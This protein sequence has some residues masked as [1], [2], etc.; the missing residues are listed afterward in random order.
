MKKLFL[1][2]MLFVS[3]GSYADG[4]VFWHCTA[5][6]A[7]G[8]VWN[9]YGESHQHTRAI[10]QKACEAFNDRKSCEMVCF[11]PRV[12]WRCMSHDL[13]SA[14]QTK[15]DAAPIKPGTWYWTSF[16]KQIAINGARDACRHNSQYG[17]CYVDPNTCA[18]SG[19]TEGE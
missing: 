5:T 16:S 6:N 15:N 9:E 2:A 18:S 1:T 7:Q 4:G 17:G 13:I 11:P 8:A 10:A 3:M 19:E 12:Y 14:K